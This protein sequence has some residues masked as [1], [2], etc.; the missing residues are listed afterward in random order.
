MRDKRPRTSPADGEADGIIEGRNAVLE[1]LRTDTPID[2]IYLAK[3]ETDAALGHIAST[4]RGKGIVVVETDRRKLDER[5]ITHSHQG[6]IAVTAVREY[7]T[8][9]DILNAAREKGEPPLIV[10]CDELSDP[11]NLGAVIRTAECA[12]AHGVIIPKRRSAGLTAIVAKTSAGA[13]SHVP[14]ARVPNLPALLKDLKKEG[15]W[16]FGTA[17]DGDTTLYDADLKGPAAIVIGSEGDGMGRLV[18]ETCDFK[19]SIPMKGKLN[20]LNASAAAAIL[21]YEAVR[22]RLGKV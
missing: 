13:V 19:V 2:K 3:G 5:S 18:A 4:A 6:V 15:V 14:V 9:E 17:A 1:A 21:L 11:H 20:S 12:G 7:A 22:Q 10:V 8:V 16:V